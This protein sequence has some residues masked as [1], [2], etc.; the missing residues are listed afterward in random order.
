M[1]TKVTTQTELDAALAR[2]AYEVIIDSPSGVWLEVR[3]TDSSRVVARDSSRV[4]A[5]G[6]TPPCTFTPGA[7]P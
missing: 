6:N 3:N 7:Q 4:D 2:G 1:T 5:R